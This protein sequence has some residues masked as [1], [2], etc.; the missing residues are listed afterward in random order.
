MWS[1]GA[2]KPRV[3]LDD[4]L[5]YG[6]LFVVNTDMDRWQGVKAVAETKCDA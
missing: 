3:D 2:R 4:N 5:P 6:G 1:L